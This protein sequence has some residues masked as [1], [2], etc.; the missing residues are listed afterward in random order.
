MFLSKALK[1][2][3]NTVSQMIGGFP[4]D[5]G[6][7]ARFALHLKFGEH[8]MDALGDVETWRDAS[9][10]GRDFAQLV[11]ASRPN[12]DG[13]GYKFDGDNENIIQK[14]AATD[15]I[16][17]IT[18]FTIGFTC[19]V[20]NAHYSSIVSIAD[21]SSSQDFI[22]FD[23]NINISVKADGQLRNITLNSVMPD[24]V[25]FSV[26]LQRDSSNVLK[27]W[28]DGVL[29]SNTATFNPG[30]TLDIDTIGCRNN[31]ISDFKGSIGEVIVYACS[32]PEL[33]TDIQ[34]RLDFI[35]TQMA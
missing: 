2:A 16:Q 18:D 24:D 9:G 11:E 8:V 23:D 5:N 28:I 12:W 25:P 15:P 1:L 21:S 33:Q 20:L 3:V 35:K 4:N 34:N 30:K 29:Q 22:R 14:S 17:I 26:I 31:Q 6:C 27:V 10:N 13:K 19:R 7:S 32:G